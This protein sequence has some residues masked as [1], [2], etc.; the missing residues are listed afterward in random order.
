M[1]NN[2]K[3]KILFVRN[4]SW[5]RKYCGYN[6]RHHCNDNQYLTYQKRKIAIKKQPPYAKSVG[7]FF[8]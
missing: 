6:N 3:G 1:E 5:Y 2:E 4:D 8:R 7:C